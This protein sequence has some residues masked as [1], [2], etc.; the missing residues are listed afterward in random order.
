[1]EVIDPVSVARRGCADA[2]V[3]TDVTAMLEL[4]DEVA[5][6]G[7]LDVA[8]ALDDADVFNVKTTLLDTLLLLLLLPMLKEVPAMDALET[9]DE[10][11]ADIWEAA[12][13][14]TV[15]EAATL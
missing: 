11:M 10:V 15:P 2:A 1:M 13:M 5:V 4:C 6:I 12:P 7:E 9:E 14:L 8:A 3:A